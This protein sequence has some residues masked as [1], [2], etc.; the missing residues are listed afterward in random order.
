[1]KHAH[2][3][4][5]NILKKYNK[6]YRQPTDNT[7]YTL[8]QI[9]NIIN[10]TFSNTINKNYLQLNGLQITN[11][12]INY[13]SNIFTLY[14]KLDNIN[15][16][17]IYF[18]MHPNCYFY[19][20]QYNPMPLYNITKECNMYKYTTKGKHFNSETHI[21]YNYSFNEYPTELFYDPI[22][23]C[24]YCLKQKS[25]FNESYILDNSLLILNN[26]TYLG[27]DFF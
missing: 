22:K 12:A 24:V 5:V 23:S 18:Y 4:V 19:L 14:L 7:Q 15:K 1:M 9:K 27:F 10:S 6:S 16:I 25:G 11:Y 3:N 20:Q 21:I 2:S 26:I 8:D 17:C 13:T